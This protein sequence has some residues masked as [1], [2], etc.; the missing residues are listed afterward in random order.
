M[1]YNYDSGSF[2]GDLGLVSLDIF[3]WAL[4]GVVGLVCAI[5]F[6]PKWV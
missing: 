1:A 4:L 5:C 2:E 3:V 6:V